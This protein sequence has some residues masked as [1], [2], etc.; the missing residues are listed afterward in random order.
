MTL[1]IPVFAK[2]IILLSAQGT[3]GSH[4]GDGVIPSHE[5]MPPTC[6]DDFF[7]L[8]SCYYIILVIVFIMGLY[9]TNA[10][11]TSRCK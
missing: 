2:I 5:E 4:Q 7:S 10:A 9:V 6:K 3:L 11:P 1:N 8:C